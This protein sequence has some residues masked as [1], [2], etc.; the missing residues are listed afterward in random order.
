VADRKSNLRTIKVS[1]RSRSTLRS[2]VNREGL[3]TTDESG[4]VY[5]KMRARPTSTQSD[6]LEFTFPFPP[7]QVSY[8][9]VAPEIA[10]IERPG[11]KPLITF[12]RFKARR[13]SLEFL[14]AV[15]YD[16]LRVNVE[17]SIEVLRSIANSG[18]PVSFYN[19]D[20]FLG[21][22]TPQGITTNGIYWSITDMSFE[23]V[24]RN[25]DQ[26]ITQA[27]V[28]MSIVENDNPGDIQV[29]TLPD[30]VYTETP[31]TQNTRDEEADAETDFISW[32]ESW[33]RY[34]R[35]LIGD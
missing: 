30:I 9:E 28:R 34:G 20:S 27:S 4:V 13:V 25:A 12:S 33:E 18:R 21:G 5:P 32:T 22:T 15:P 10:E 31:A 3:I 19:A 8:S 1:A 6:V 14:V 11:Q 35:P 16:G 24:R 17:E 23:S 26:R 2:I 7:T 29:I